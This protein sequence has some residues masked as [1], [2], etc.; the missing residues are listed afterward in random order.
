MFVFKCFV[1]N[2]RYLMMHVYSFQVNLFWL[3]LDR[4]SLGLS[5]QQKF[6]YVELEF[7]LCNDNSKYETAYVQTNALFHVCSHQKLY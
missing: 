6:N 2:L 5:C 3:R 7:L 4:I 1:E